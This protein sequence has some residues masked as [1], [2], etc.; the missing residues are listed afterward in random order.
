MKHSITTAIAVAAFAIGG[1][2]GYFAK[3]NPNRYELIGR[4]KFDRATGRLWQ[5]SGDAWHELGGAPQPTPPPASVVQQPPSQPVAQPQPTP[6]KRSW[7]QMKEEILN[8]QRQAE[9][10]RQ[11][12]LRKQRAQADQ[13]F[14]DHMNQTL[15]VK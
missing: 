6:D 5:L 10:Q 2:T 15:K 8:E 4:R 1:V 7:A 9:E 13:P 14:I 3:P 12:Y 11:D